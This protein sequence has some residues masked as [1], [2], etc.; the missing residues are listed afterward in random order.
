MTSTSSGRSDAGSASR[1]ILAWSKPTSTSHPAAAD[2]VAVDRVARLGHEL[3][4][5]VLHDVAR[6]VGVAQ[7]PGG[8]TRERRGLL[9]ERAFEKIDVFMRECPGVRR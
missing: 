6:P 9:R 8:V 7:E 1:V 2:R 4:E 3:D 5:R